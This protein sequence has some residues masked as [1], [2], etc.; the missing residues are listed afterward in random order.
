MFY[1]AVPNVLMALTDYDYYHKKTMIKN[2]KDYLPHVYYLGQHKLLFNF[3]Q[4]ISWLSEAIVFSM[5]GFFL[6]IYFY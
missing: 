5:L 6:T 4:Y 3:K 1:T 2:G